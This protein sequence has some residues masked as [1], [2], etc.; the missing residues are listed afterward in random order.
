MSLVR[1]RRKMMTT[2][3]IFVYGFV[4]IFILGIFLSFNFGNTQSSARSENGVFATID[5]KP[6]PMAQYA[7][8]LQNLA[9]QYRQFG[10]GLTT[11]MQAE[12]PHYAYDQVVRAYAEAKAAEKFGIRVSTGEAE[13][14]ARQEID[15]QLK[16]LGEGLKP[17]ELSQYR[18]LMYSNIDVEAQQRQLL[19]KKLR[20]KLSAEAR[21]VEVKVAHILIKADKRSDAQA[22][23]LAEDLVRQARG[24]ADFAKLAEKN[25]EDAGSKVKGGEVGWASAQPPS[26]PSGKDAKP[27]PEAAT[28]FVPE[29]T[30]AALRLKVGEISEPTKSTF[31]YH[32]LKALAIRDFKP[33]EEPTA[34]SKPEV[35]KTPPAKPAAGKPADPK[36][37]DP[38]KEAAAKKAK[39]AA[40]KRQ[41]AIDTYK[42]SAGNAIADGLFSEYKARLE[43]KVAPK[44]K[45]L[46]G[47]LLEKQA[48][49]A[50]ALGPDGKPVNNNAKLAGAIAAY[51]LAMKNGE[52]AASFGLFYKLAQLHQ[53]VAQSL[54]SEKKSAEAKAEYKKALELLVKNTRGNDAEMY[55]QQGE[56]Q[57][58]LGD[59]TKALAAY[60]TAMEKAEKG[61]PNPAI[62]GRLSEKFKGLGRKDLQA[63]ATDRQNELQKQ[64]DQARQ[65]QMQNISLGK[66][67]TPNA[68]GS[69]S[70]PISVTI[71]PSTGKT[72]G[73]ASSPV[74]ITI[75]GKSGG[76]AAAEKGKDAGT[77]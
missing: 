53:R 47:Y 60:K 62:M 1:M 43:S 75:P 15:E 12:M 36:A 31:G 20:D 44:S 2:M 25:S 58:K 48:D 70:K 7:V 54:E 65:A 23:K 73:G 38:A 14:A 55:L 77:P 68:G 66:P 9:A 41:Q 63:K 74:S 32:V 27:D 21:P 42:T 28:S 30:S 4:A 59:K 67:R 40:E 45:W 24:G 17:E 19:A 6:V 22:E 64:E 49:A 61:R 34:A 13:T 72:K 18:Q 3:M 5:G 71:P 52:P 51:E 37:A 57:E 10:G 26:P 46:E 33:K 16:R 29:F 35:V 39:E 50:L 56:V 8:T 69:T 76:D 11:Q